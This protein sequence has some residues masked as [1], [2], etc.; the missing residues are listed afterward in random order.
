[1]SVLLLK[2]AGP[3][4]SWGSSSRFARRGT[5]VAPTKSGVLGL[6][7]AAR[8]IRRTEPLTELLGLEFGVR[9]DQPGQ[10]MRDF[11]VTRSLDGR[12][13]FPLT[14]RYYLADAVF[15]AA[16]GGPDELLHGLNEALQRPAFPL[17]LGRRSC[18]PAG[19]ISLGVHDGDVDGRLGDFPWCAADWFR[20]RADSRVHLELIR[21][22]GPGEAITETQCD[23]PISFDPARRQHAWR[24]VVRRH[25]EITNDLADRSVD[26]DPMSLLGG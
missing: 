14:Y 3:M 16:V 25:T 18:P 20:K 8:G 5:E 21:D 13:R 10:I 7:A 4:Q 9:I 2:L 22:A 1:M 15:L 6:L 17:F 11:Q 26:H 19:R 23:E 12:T 24:P